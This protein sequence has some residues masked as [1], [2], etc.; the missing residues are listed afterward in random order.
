[1]SK[2]IDDRMINMWEHQREGVWDNIRFN[3]GLV[4]EKINSNSINKIE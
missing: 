4:F 1:M 2:K 3:M